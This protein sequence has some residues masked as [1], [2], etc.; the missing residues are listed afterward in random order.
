MVANS[1]L[2]VADLT[3]NSPMRVKR[4]AATTVANTSKNPSTQRCTTHQRQYSAMAKLV[5]LPHISPAPQKSAMAAQ[6]RKKR[7]SIHRSQV[8][9]L[10]MVTMRRIINH[11]HRKRPTTRSIC[12]KR[13]K[14]T[15]SYPW[16]PDQ[17]LFTKSKRCITPNQCPI[18]D[19]ATTISRATN[20]TFTPDFWNLGS[21]PL[22]EGAI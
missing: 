1:T 16:C 9:C 15:Y 19:P 21:R 8:L 10:I 5:V 22:N 11:N 13:P 17:K 12:Q 2:L 18:I 3:P 14:S 6:E 4:N 7:I 20:S